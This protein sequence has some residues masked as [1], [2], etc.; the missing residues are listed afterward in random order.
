MYAEAHTLSTGHGESRTRLSVRSRKPPKLPPGG[1][2]PTISA[3]AGRARGCPQNRVFDAAG[4]D[5]D[6]RLA[7]HSVQQIFQPAPRLVLGSLLRRMDIASRPTTTPACDLARRST[8]SESLLSPIAQTHTRRSKGRGTAGGPRFRAPSPQ[9]DR[10]HAAP[11]R[12][13][14]L[15]DS[16]SSARLSR[17]RRAGSAF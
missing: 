16:G 5:L 9:I 15:T 13:A 10:R 12:T 11:M 4:C 17:F 2:P 8:R 1:C 7:A 14:D 3:S 6:L